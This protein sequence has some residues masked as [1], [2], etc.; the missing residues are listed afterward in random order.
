MAVTDVV[1][2]RS[3]ALTCL[4]HIG[5]ALRA[6]RATVPRQLIA[7]PSGLLGR[8]LAMGLERSCIGAKVEFAEPIET[9]PPSPTRT[10]AKSADRRR[11]RM[12]SCR[13]CSR[14]RGTRPKGNRSY[15]E[16]WI[17]TRE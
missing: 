16:Q 12:R 3:D 15:D 9:V 7:R 17:G 2:A 8:I 13:A 4:R 14:C 10:C 1:A 5:E 11:R 6:A